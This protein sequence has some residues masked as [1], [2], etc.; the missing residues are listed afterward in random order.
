M[1]DNIA[2]IG[3]GNMGSSL[4]GG[5]L[6]HGYPPQKICIA[7]P[8]TEK[9]RP[10]QEK[11]HVEISTDNITAVKTASTVIIAVKPQIFRQVSQEIAPTAQQQK[12]LIISIAAGIST[13]QIENM[14]GKGLSIV[15]CMPNTPALIG[16]GASALFA[17][18]HVSTQQRSTAERIFRTAGITVWLEEEKQ[19]DIVTAL[20]GSGPAYFFLFMEALQQAGEQLGLNPEIARSLTVQTAYGAA[21]MALESDKNVIE[22]RKAVTSPAGTTERAIQVLEK[23]EIR[24]II[25]NTLL[26]A[27]QRAQELG[28]EN[29]DEQ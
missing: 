7:D 16:C 22:L 23:A 4:L 14:T 11:F 2:I 19:M 27:Q 28:R 12:P 5:L 10:L 1:W 18:P 17:N 9:L 15:R 21:K 6:T 13:T 25:M 20:S 8:G 3:A 26:A 29:T 24:D